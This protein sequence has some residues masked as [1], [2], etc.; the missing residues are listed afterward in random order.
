[1]LMGPYVA[2]VKPWDTKGVGGVFR[3]LNRSS[4]NILVYAASSTGQPPYDTSLCR[5]GLKL[6]V[7]AV[8]AVFRFLNMSTPPPPRAHLLLFAE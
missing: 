5:R 7:Y 8:E 3:F 4:L 1:M 6:L 2:Q